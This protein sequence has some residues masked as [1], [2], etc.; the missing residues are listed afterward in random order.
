LKQQIIST[1]R[2]RL[3]QW[4]VI[5]TSAL[6]SIAFLYFGYLR[7]LNQEY[8][9]AIFYSFEGVFLFIFFYLR[10]TRLHSIEYD[11]QHIYVVQKGQE[12]IIPF[13]DIKDIK[14]TG[15][16]GVHSIYLYEDLGFDKEIMFKSS[17]WYPFN[18]KKV[19]DQVYELQKRIDQAKRE[20]KPDN[21]H[22]L[23]S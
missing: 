5:I 7:Y 17:L 15:L 12:L 10:A 6:I 13:T 20:Y 1:K 23:G 19:D 14:L 4:I 8:F 22:A 11:E 18:Y 16:T 2:L 9:G 3:Y 21:Y